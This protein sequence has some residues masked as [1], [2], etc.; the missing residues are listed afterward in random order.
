MQP[1]DVEKLLNETDILKVLD[2]CLS[3]PDNQSINI[4]FLKLEATWILT[5]IGYGDEK[6][7]ECIFEDKYKFISHLNRILKGSDL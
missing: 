7:I 2:N 3:V 4:R 5:N 6:E 1:V